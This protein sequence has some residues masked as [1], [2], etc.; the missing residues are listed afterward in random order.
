M[1]MGSRM[2]RRALIIGALCVVVAGGGSVAWAMTSASDK[3]V[4]C[5]RKSGGAL[6]LVEAAKD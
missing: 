3:F 1:R 2:L 5:A 4:A 6:R